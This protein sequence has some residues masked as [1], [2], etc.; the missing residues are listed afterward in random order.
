VVPV[1]HAEK[2]RNKLSKAKI[3]IYKNMNG[4][5]IVSKLPQV[6]KMIKNDVKNKKQ[7][8]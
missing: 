1:A 7:K 4:H 3:K 6:I 2:Y 8:I 5:F